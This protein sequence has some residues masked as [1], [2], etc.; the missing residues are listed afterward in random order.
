[1]G[2]KT[3]L[4]E[5]RHRGRA[6]NP[7]ASAELPIGPLL[8]SVLELMA[9]LQ[10]ECGWAASF[11]LWRKQARDAERFS[12]GAR[13]NKADTA[14]SSRCSFP[15]RCRRPFLCRRSEP[16]SCAQDHVI[17]S[18]GGTTVAATCKTLSTLVPNTA[19]TWRPCL[20][21][22]VSSVSHL[23]EDISDSVPLSCTPQNKPDTEPINPFAT[24]LLRIPQD[25]H[26]TTIT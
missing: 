8:L 20:V 16:P 3:H 11:T 6:D 5:A 24:G 2:W 14:S 12:C 13:K 21:K 15:F 22:S 7:I 26:F 19:L 9:E 10:L 23:T 17:T 4:N 25:K 1:M 18:C